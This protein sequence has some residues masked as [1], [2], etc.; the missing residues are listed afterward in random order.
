MFMKMCDNAARALIIILIKKMA[1]N[2]FFTTELIPKNRKKL[3]RS[4]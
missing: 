1:E 2:Y 4:D 3:E